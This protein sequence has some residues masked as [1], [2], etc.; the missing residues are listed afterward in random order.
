MIIS[1]ISDIPYT[2]LDMLDLSELIIVEGTGGM[3]PEPPQ[4]STLKVN[5]P[6]ASIEAKPICFRNPEAPFSTL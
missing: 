2:M 4:K 1:C 3:P 5:I 6:F